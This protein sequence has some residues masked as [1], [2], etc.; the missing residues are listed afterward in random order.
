MPAR[1]A[2][3]DAAHA[4]LPDDTTATVS[5]PVSLAWLIPADTWRSLKEP[6]GFP[7]SFF[8]R[9]RPMPSVSPKLGASTRGVAPS[10]R[11]TT[12]SRESRG[13]RSKYVH[14]ER[15]GASN[16]ARSGV[17]RQRTLMGS[18]HATQV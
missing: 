14:I 3:A 6:V 4:T 17:A 8:K 16:S 12:L 11:L 10:P 15:A 2:Y 13:S 1:A 5:A 9:R 7:I 18:P